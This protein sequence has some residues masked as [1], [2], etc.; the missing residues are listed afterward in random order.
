MLESLKKTILSALKTVA[1]TPDDIRSIVQGFVSRGDITEEQ[2]RKI[3]DALLE[4]GKEGEETRDRMA[5]EFQRISD[6]IPVV[7]KSEF[8]ELAERV[9]RIEERLGPPPQ[10]PDEVPPDGGG[11]R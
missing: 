4:R 8:R 9:R 3:V 10:A 5:G 1:L 7:S 11:P 2:G 6:L